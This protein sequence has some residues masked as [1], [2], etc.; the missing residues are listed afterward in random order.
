MRA[1][2]NTV[3]GGL[4]AITAWTCAAV[5]LPADM[6]GLRQLGTAKLTVFGFEI[7]NARLWVPAE[8]DRADYARHP[9]VLELTYLRDF[10][11]QAIAERSIK[12]MRGVD[13]FTDAQAQLWL[14]ALTQVL[15]D[16]KKGDRLTGVYQPGK[17]LRL[18][19]N[20]APLPALSDPTLA[21]V[22][23]GIW[24]SPR[25]SEPAMR[26]ALLSGAN[27]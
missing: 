20:D 17:A 6:P 16:V 24:L 23:M 8:F 7:Y 26:E 18:M 12:E 25:T 13:V 10:K 15:P 3:C 1:L 21:R 14:T 19:F 4:L 27:R 22:F 9:H 11:G 2:R 5:V